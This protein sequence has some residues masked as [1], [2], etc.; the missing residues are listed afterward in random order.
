MTHLT[1]RETEARAGDTEWELTDP[2]D[3]PLS[4][5]T[6]LHDSCPVSA[7]L[8]NQFHLQSG[9]FKMVTGCGWGGVEN[10]RRKPPGG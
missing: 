10:Q 1:D 2:W 6:L 9:G 8:Q 7:S 4:H 3:F 5:P